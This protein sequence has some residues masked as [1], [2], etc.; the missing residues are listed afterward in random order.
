MRNPKMIAG[1]VVV[2]IIAALGYAAIAADLSADTKPAAVDAEQ[3]ADF[4]AGEVLDLENLADFVEGQRQYFNRIT[5]PGISWVQP[6]FP[7]VAPFDAAYFADSFLDGLLG[8][9][10]YSV[11][12]YPLSFSLDPKTR[13]TLVYNAD[14]K[15]ILTLPASMDAWTTTKGEDDPARV[16]LQLNLL[17]VEDVEPYL[18]V[19]ERISETESSVATKSAKGG[20]VAMKSLGSNEFG[21]AD[22][23][24]QT[25]GAM[26]ITTST[27]GTGTAEVFSFTVWHTNTLEIVTGTNGIPVTNTI[28]WAASAPYNGVDEVWECRTTNLVFTNGVA[29]WDDTD[30][31]TNARQRMYSIAL[32]TD[33]DGD[34]LTDGSEFFVYHTNRELEDTD[35]DGM[36]DG[37]EVLYGLNPFAN[38]GLGDPDE[39]GIPNVYEQSHA[40]NPTNSDAASVTILRVDPSA[41]GSNVFAN[42]KAAF[43]ASEAYSIIEVADGIYS[44]SGINTHLWFPEHPVMLCSDNVGSSRQ[45]VFTYYGEGVAFYFD[46]QQDNHT[47]IRGITLRMSGNGSYQYGFWLGPGIYYGQAGAAPI[48]DGVTVETGESGNNIAFMCYGPAPEPIIF[49]N[50]VFRGKPG[51]SVPMRGIYAMDSSALQIINCSFLDFPSAPYA[52]G[53]QLHSRYLAE[54]GLV[55]IANCLWDSSFTASNPTPPFV[56]Y[57]QFTNSAPYFVHVADSIMPAM[58]TWFLPDAQT[59]LYITNAM[60]AMGGHLQTNS[61]GIDAGGPTLTLADFEGQPRDATPDIGADEYAALGSGDTDGDGLSDS[62]EVETYGTDPYRADSDGDNISDGTEV[63]DGTDLTDPASY[64]FEVLGVATN[65]SGNS[66]AVWVCRRWGAGAWDTNTAAIATNG[67]FTIDVLA[68]NQTNT[69]NVG[70][71]CDY[72]TNG[73]PDAVEPVYWKT[74]AAT[75]SLMRTSFLLKDYDG[76]FI[77]DWQE[78]LCGT[79]P[80]SASNYCV[81]VSGILTNIY[82]DSGNYYVG[83]SLSTNAANMV[84]VTNVAIDG[85]FAFSHI[86]MTNISSILYLMHFDDVNTNG[87][88]DTNELYGHNATNRSKGHTF[89]WIPEARDYDN[90]DMPDFWEVRKSFNWTNQVDCVADA[91][92]DG[93]YN[94]LECWMKTDP[95]SV[96]ISS[97]TAIRNAIAAVDEKLAGL[98]PSTAL[99]IFSVQNHAATNYVWNTN[100]WAYSYDLTCYSPWNTTDTNAP[101]FRPGTLISPRHVIFAAHYAASSNKTI[102]FVDRQNNVVV[103]QI[104]KVV[105]HPAYPVPGDYLYPDLAV[106]LLD[107]DVP[108][109]QISF[110]RVLSDTHTNYLSRG[111]RLPALALNQFH[112]ASVCDIKEIAGRHSDGTIRTIVQMPIDN[113]RKGFYTGIVGGDSGNPAFVFLSGKPVLLTVWSYPDAGTSVTSL[114]QDINDMMSELGGGYQLTEIDLSGFRSLDE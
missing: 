114:K 99:P 105:K 112:K 8:E 69:L 40:T 9:D 91:D 83:L 95:Y 75:G 107:S 13:E 71:F 52:Y 35:G 57:L 43:D 2:V 15:L 77:S 111:T 98:T 76:D 1:I 46:A 88:W 54:T 94:V 78:V 26:R 24:T 23:Q 59:N 3:Y 4:M 34:G 48:F 90:D 81:S 79:D 58:P 31:P 5:P 101:W 47:I 39:D 33:T 42:L 50:C 92:A 100:C 80:L 102:R 12:V 36:L 51:K 19:E 49:N 84:A 85:T 60:V 96:N 55:E 30:I 28:W 62:L 66:S 89:Y 72:N 16:T 86:I 53:V 63:A 68:T 29:V 11:A 20:G 73:L 93:F 27:N 64:R 14:G 97:N 104:I 106:G 82:I 22:I 70:A 6:M 10:K 21:I 108:T 65:Q 44:G 17:P 67:N 74:V 103:R 32:R 7:S 25:N 110:A 37:W 56:T 109:N 87:M 38:D 41:S 45:T 61:P 113:S 18:Y